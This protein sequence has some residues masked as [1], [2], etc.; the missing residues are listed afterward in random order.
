MKCKILIKQGLTQ[1]VKNYPTLV[2]ARKAFKK[3]VSGPAFDFI[4]KHYE[5]TDT[6]TIFI[7]LT[8]KTNQV[9]NTKPYYLTT[10]TD[11][12]YLV[13]GAYGKGEHVI[14]GIIIK[15]TDKEYND[16]E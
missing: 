16:Y 3:E 2:E 12:L 9:V 5:A 1:F 10:S 11:F 14:S 13:D 4:K 6:A 8:K 15:E 7:P